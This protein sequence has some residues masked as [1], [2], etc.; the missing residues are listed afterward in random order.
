MFRFF[1]LA[2][3]FLLSAAAL[4][5]E[6]GTEA[7]P[8]TTL[9]V[10]SRLV[11]V[12]VLVRDSQ[13]NVVR[14]LTQQDFKLTEDS[15]PQAIDFFTAHTPEPAAA[16]ALAEPELVAPKTEFTNVHPNGGSKSITIVLCDLLNTPNDDQLTA[17]Q[18]MLKF[19]RSL[20]KGER[21]AL[22]TLGNGLQAVQGDAGSP[23]L[24][25]NASKMLKPVQILDTS[26][27]GE[28]SDNMVAAN[29]AAQF[30]RH[31]APST[32]M[33]QSGA[34]NSSQSYDVRA[35]S[36][37]TALGQVAST[38]AGYPGR[39][40][41]YWLAESFPLSVDV[42]GP[43]TYTSL[44]GNGT[45]FNAQLLTLQGHFSQTSRQEMRTTLNQLASARIAVYPTSVF[46]LVTQSATAAIGGP[47]G[48]GTA[49]PG[50]PRG[51]SFTLGN[52]KTEMNDL[53]RETGGEAIVGSNDV[54]GAMQKTLED[55]ATYYSLA[56]RPTNANWNGNFRTIK[57]EASGGAS[58]TYR[59]GYFALANGPSAD[60]GS[61]LETVLQPGVPEVAGLRLHAKVLPADPLHPGLVVQSTIEAADVNF[62]TTADGHHHA[63]LKVQLIGFNDGE[64]QPKS[65]PQTS[66]TLNI[67]L[68]PDRYKIIL[69]AGIAFRQQLAL[70]PGKYHVLLGVSDQTSQKLGTVDMALVVPAS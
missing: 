69:T 35:Q 23:A 54:A 4:C 19:L 18:Q 31:P 62:T 59:R 52:L 57:V 44:S 6:T 58:L 1:Q 29:A 45:Q 33:E 67:D 64:Q 56:Y 43:P 37:I 46:G 10:N 70:K 66:G 25:D 20:P 30:G 32:S 3:I 8:L 22:F 12:D 53:A 48:V 34:A 51:G 2:A 14:G 55:G 28:A 27:T 24:L 36:T 60:S 39:K 42:A 5:Q 40:S 26:R 49:L 15:Q 47:A 68:D 50:D 65:L 11:F 13:G 41:L 38:M 21:I 63:K 16:A 17:R 61:D 7:A 9:H